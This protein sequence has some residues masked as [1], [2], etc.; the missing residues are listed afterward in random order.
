MAARAVLEAGP[1]RLLVCYITLA[2]F[3]MRR[4][5]KVLET[6]LTCTES[7][8][9]RSMH[10]F[11]LARIGARAATR[12]CSHGQ[13]PAALVGSTASSTAACSAAAVVAVAAGATAAACDLDESPRDAYGGITVI[14][15][16]AGPPEAFAAALTASLDRWRRDGVRGVWL[17]V[18][19][20]LVKYLP[21]AL[22]HGFTLRGG[23]ATHVLCCAWLPGGE[24]PLP[25]GPT[26]QVG[27]GAVVT[28]RV[29]RLLLVQEAVGP[30]QG[31]WKLPTGLC[32]SNEDV[33]QAAAREVREETGLEVRPAEVLAVRHSHGFHRGVSDVFFCVRCE[34]IDEG[35]ALTPQAGEIARVEW[36]PVADAHDAATPAWRRIYQIAATG[37]GMRVDTYPGRRGATATC[38]YSSG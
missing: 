5:L 7:R 6:A 28:D 33:G 4:R 14:V 19:A 25:P 27:V 37:D 34:V 23:D 24:S 21:A 11:R 3:F 18:P 16:D 15:G 30:A 29:G 9:R 31:R 20:A 10:A 38:I 13:L 2:P 35:A 17:E 8:Q 36:R 22:D 1:G 26:H 12:L 32:E